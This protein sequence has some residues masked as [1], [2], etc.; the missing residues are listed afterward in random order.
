ME[1]MMTRLGPPIVDGIAKWIRY[2]FPYMGELF[3]QASLGPRAAVPRIMPSLGA[4]NNDKNAV[5]VQKQCGELSL[6]RVRM[7]G[8]SSG[9]LEVRAPSRRPLK[10][11]HGPW[12]EI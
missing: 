1:V 11:A 7:D 9:A 6:R 5:Q 10:V 8:L 3:S 2:R 12:P 4:D